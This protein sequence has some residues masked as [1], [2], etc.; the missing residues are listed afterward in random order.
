MTRFFTGFNGSI[1]TL[2]HEEPRDLQMAETTAYIIS[3]LPLGNTKEPFL[4]ILVGLCVLL[5]LKE[6]E[7]FSQ[8]HLADFPHTI[9]E[10][11]PSH[12]R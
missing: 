4:L 11:L 9:E 6:R 10:T 12:N 2:V 8:V 7:S 5:C 1:S 3:M